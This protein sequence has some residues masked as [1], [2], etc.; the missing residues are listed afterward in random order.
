MSYQSPLRDL[1][2]R[3]DEVAKGHLAYSQAADA[4][5][6]LRD[7]L[8]A[9]AYCEEVNRERASSGDSIHKPAV[10]RGDGA[11]AAG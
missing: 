9:I 4:I 2:R 3:I 11:S 10:D 1:I 8:S 7:H 5:K 6:N